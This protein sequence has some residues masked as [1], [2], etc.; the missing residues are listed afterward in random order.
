MALSPDGANLVYVARREGREELYLRPIAE[1]EAR[2]ISGTYGA[3]GLFFSPD[4]LWVGFSANG[5]LRKV[6]LAGGPSVS[7]CDITSSHGASWGSD[8]TIYFSPSDTSGIARVSAEGGEPEFVTT[9]EPEKGDLGHYWPE[10]LPGGNAGLFKG[11]RQV[12]SRGR[13]TSTPVGV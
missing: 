3:R 2:P 4:G 12:W 10:V 1:P 11:C 6:P 7:L 8:D 13:P 9:P 5:K